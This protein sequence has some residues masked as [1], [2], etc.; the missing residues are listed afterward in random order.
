[1]CEASSKSP[2]SF[3]STE[4]VLSYAAQQAHHNKAAPTSAE[5]DEQDGENSE[6]DNDGA[7]VA[8]SR[9]GRMKQVPTNGQLIFLTGFGFQAYQMAKACGRSWTS[10]PQ[11]YAK[12]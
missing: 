11:N 4:L 9:A 3:H 1:M 10:R 12:S 6:V 7:F 2:D 5:L 8:V